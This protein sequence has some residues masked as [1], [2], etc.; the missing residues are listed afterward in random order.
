MSVKGWEGGGVAAIFFDY[1]RVAGQLEVE[2]VLDETI[3]DARS[4]PEFL[5]RMVRNALDAR[6]PT[7]FFGD[8][9]VEHSGTHAGKLDVKHGGIMPITDL[10]RVH[11][12]AA[13][14]NAKRTLE[15][16]RAAAAAGRIDEETLAGLDEAFR[17]LWQARLEHQVASVRAGSPPDDFVDPTT[18]PP[19]RRRALKEAFRIIARAQKALKA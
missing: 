17:L 1:R 3:R 6:P 19:L 2:R 10:A 11:S 12:I 18:L 8:F 13:G 7:G 5:E 14:L 4:R 15:R 9:V 16:L